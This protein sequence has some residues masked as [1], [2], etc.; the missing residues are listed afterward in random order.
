MTLLS[1]LLTGGLSLSWKLSRLKFGPDVL[2]PGIAS[3]CMLV[4]LVRVASRS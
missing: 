4:T 3:G 1:S 2:A